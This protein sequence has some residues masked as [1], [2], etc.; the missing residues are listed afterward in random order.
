MSAALDVDGDVIGGEMAFHT[1]N[2][3][4]FVAA[5]NAYNGPATEGDAPLEQPLTVGEPVADG[6]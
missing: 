4:E 3:A 1:P 2:A 6:S 5:Y